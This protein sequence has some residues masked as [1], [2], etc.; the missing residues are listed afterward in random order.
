MFRKKD[1][2]IGWGLFLAMVA[3]VLLLIGKQLDSLS[4]T[5][6]N[7]FIEKVF[8]N[9]STE[10]IREFQKTESLFNDAV[11]ALQRDTLGQRGDIH[12]FMQFIS[13][14]DHKVSGVWFYP[15]RS[16]TFLYIDRTHEVYKL[17]KEQFRDTLMSR[18][19]SAMTR[20]SLYERDGS[21]M[22]RMAKQ[23]VLN[24]DRC[25]VGFDMDLVE[26][27]DYF[28]ELSTISDSYVFITNKDG[29]ILSHPEERYIGQVLSDSVEYRKMFVD[30][31]QTGASYEME[32]FSPF[33]SMSIF[34]KFYPLSIGSEN[35]AVAVNVPTIINRERVATFQYHVITITLVF[36]FLLTAVAFY[37]R[38]RWMRERRL[39]RQVER[40]SELMHINQLKSK[41]DPHFLFNSLNSLHALIGMNDKL[42]KEFVV[43]L[44]KVYRQLLETDSAIFST[45]GDEIELM[46]QYYFLQKIRFGEALCMDIDASVSNVKHLYVPTLSLQLLVEN[47]IK[48]NIV[49]LSRPLCI[50]IYV[51]GNNLIVSNN[52]QQRSNDEVDSIGLGYEGITQIYNRVG[53]SVFSWYIKGG[54]YFCV[55]PLLAP[56]VPSKLQ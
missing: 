54:S 13:L 8:S 27:H 25:I 7:E 37:A 11:D 44:S 15:E 24:G 12:T 56:D 51:E 53:G 23:I 1:I 52:F 46:E 40:E 21:L 26:L 10:V 6:N 18:F 35:W 4:H 55:L 39:R 9:R 50:N 38:K 36:L 42:A 41:M 43:K 17:H 45:V 20:S 32:L 2:Y 19:N 49:T 28:A 14:A 30:M 3:V 5:I 34:R 48:H 22:W 29:I 16:D 33:L 47:A 31:Q